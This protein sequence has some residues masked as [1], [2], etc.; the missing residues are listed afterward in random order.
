MTVQFYPKILAR[1]DKSFMINDLFVVEAAGVEP[2]S[3]INVSRKTPCV[4]YSEDSLSQL[5][6]DKK[7]RE[8]VR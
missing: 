2:A 8:L 4:V 5:R 3:E 7:P 6:T 1:S